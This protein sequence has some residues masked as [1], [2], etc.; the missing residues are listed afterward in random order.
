MTATVPRATR[1]PSSRAAG[2][3][4][5]RVR[6][7]RSASRAR[8][9]FVVRA[10]DPITV[11]DLL[12]QIQTGHD[13]SLAFR[14]S[15]RVAMCGTCGVRV[16]GRS[17]LAC[18]AV[19][20]PDVDEIEVA[21]LAGLPVVRDLIVDTRPFWAEWARVKPWFVPAGGEPV[22]VEVGSAAEELVESAL[23]CI[24]CGACYSSCEIAGHGSD[25]IGP[26]ALNRALALIADPRDGAAEER[27]EIVGGRGGVDRCHYIGA[28]TSACPVGLD[29][30]RSIVELRRLRL[31]GRA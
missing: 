17:R 3:R 6:V 28:C 26:A 14:Y 19:L 15:C 5:V 13:A 11:L 7:R 25:Y 27:L 10:S 24:S 30:A 8:E 18:R 23:G 21:P 4:T 20:E 31:A 22:Q 12:R 9:E 29:P 16:D 2:E 1:A